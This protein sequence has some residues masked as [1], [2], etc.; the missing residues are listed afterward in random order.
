MKEIKDIAL[1]IPSAM[2]DCSKSAEDLKKIEDLFNS[3]SSFSD[4]MKHLG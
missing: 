1:E 4:F 3:F 2:R